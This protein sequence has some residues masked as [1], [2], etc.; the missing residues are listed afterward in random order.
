LVGF[1]RLLPLI[2][3]ALLLALTNATTMA[4]GAL[5][6]EKLNIIAISFCAILFGLGDDF[7]LLLCQRFFQS[8]NAGMT[9]K[10][11]IADSIAHCA[12]GILWVAFTTG[13]G[14]LAL[15]LSGSSGFAQLGVLVALG[16]LL[17]AVL[18]PIF[19]F[20]LSRMHLPRRRQ[21]ARCAPSSANVSSLQVAS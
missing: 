17:C 8:R 18:M 6:F 4:F 1:R 21:P 11:A 7:S 10:T 16:V 12:P 19:L 20:L 14:F 13:I 2:G 9:R 5:Y 15:C 3:I